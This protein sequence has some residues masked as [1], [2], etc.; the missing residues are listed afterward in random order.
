MNSVNAK[1]L[2][3]A[4]WENCVK[5]TNGIIDAIIT[6]DVGPRII[7][8]GFCNDVNE[9]CEYPDQVGTV[10]G[11][12]W[13]IFGGHRLWHS[14]EAKPRTYQPDNTKIDWKEI[15]N[16]VY[17]IQPTESWTH[18]Q[19][20]IEFVLEPNAP[21][22]TVIHSLTN[23]GPWP[24]E[25]AVWALSVMAPGGKAIIPHPQGDPKALLPNRVLALW[26]YTNMNDKRVYWGDKFTILSQDTSATCPFKVGLS[27]ADGW[28]AYANHNHLFVK[29]F[30][31]DEDGNYP[32]FGVSV[33]SYTDERM[34]ELETIS[35]LVTLEPGE[36][37]SYEENW[38]LIDNVKAPSNDDD[39]VKNIIPYIKSYPFY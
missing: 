3:Y 2:P 11:D 4:G 32:D 37:V 8:F 25:L 21:S 16:G 31:Y 34:L 23:K 13:N 1:V 10:G 6:T 7:F 24:I 26:P 39:V 33:E 27:V 14:P 36:S 35:P 17:I 30:I 38:V 19:K 5:I 28:T 22:A 9:F 15:K 12:E 29:Y 20:T 18:I